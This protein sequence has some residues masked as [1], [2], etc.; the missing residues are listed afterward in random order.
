MRQASSSSS[1]AL[2]FGSASAPRAW[3]ASSRPSRRAEKNNT[4]YFKGRSLGK[5]FEIALNLFFHLR[6]YAL[7][8]RLEDFFA[9]VA[10]RF[11][12]VLARQAELL[13]VQAGKAVFDF[14]VG[15]L[16]H[17]G[18]RD[19]RSVREKAPALAEQTGHRHVA[20]LAAL[21]HLLHRRL[22]LL[23]RLR[24]ALQGALFR[25]HGAGRVE[26]VE[27]VVR[28]AHGFARFADVLHDL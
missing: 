11:V 25:R 12:F 10:R 14:E 16:R 24:E 28:A 13:R 9:E 26:L 1:P 3:T 23:L 4:R 18:Q 5:V 2:N 22:H 20:E 15:K 6:R 21:R 7:L 27:P 19:H 17:A 8:E